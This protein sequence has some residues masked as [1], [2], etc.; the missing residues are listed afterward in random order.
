MRD[1]GLVFGHLRRIREKDAPQ[2][3]IA[4]AGSPRVRDFEHDRVEGF[5]RLQFSLWCVGSGAEI[6][7]S[8]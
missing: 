1:I 3:E 2:P 4:R 5:I 7:V 6:L 8:P